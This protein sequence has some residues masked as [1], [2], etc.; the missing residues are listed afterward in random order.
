MN[1]EILA[2]IT[3]LSLQKR[4]I[5]PKVALAICAV[6]VGTIAASPMRAQVQLPGVNLGD[7]NFED[8]FAGPGFLLEEFPDVYISGTL[9]DSN[10]ATVPGSNTT[11]T[12]LTTSHFVYVSNKRLFGAWIAGE[13]LFP[14]ADVQ[15]KRAQGV[16]AT[17]RG[18]ADPIV[19][20]IALQWAPRK[21][22]SG[23]F[24]GRAEFALT[25]PVGKYSD[26]RPVNIGNHFVLINPLY[27]V[28]YEWKRKFEVSARLHYL[29][30]SVNT[31]PFVDFG[32]K[33]TQPGQAFH[34][35]YA[36]SYAV[37]KDFRVGLNGYWLQQLTDDQINGQ[38]V[39]NSKERTIGLGPGVRFGG[40]SLFFS[41]N[42]YIETDVRNRPAGTRV[43][44]R[45]SK[46]FPSR[47][48][49]P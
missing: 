41:V 13:L 18:F 5:L 6:L 16:D 33:S 29:W 37:L 38:N 45:I 47:E 8:G 36:T 31:D 4:T 15:I 27:A 35:N 17:E 12:I 43:T 26:Q 21:I 30:N 32:I 11:T 1:M 39:P 22:G 14:M 20:P 49:K 44:F 9:K 3:Q 7:T 48:V 2:S 46:T 40:D 24:V 34:M 19:G 23:V 28:T 42:G 25:I 10:G